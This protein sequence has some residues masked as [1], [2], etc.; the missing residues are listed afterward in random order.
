MQF[1]EKKKQEAQKRR[2]RV[3]ITW[4]KQFLWMKFKKFVGIDIRV[5]WLSESRYKMISLVYG[6]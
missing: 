4:S 2:I 5:V 1:K 3:G 6:F